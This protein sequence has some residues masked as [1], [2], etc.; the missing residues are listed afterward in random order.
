MPKKIKKTQDNEYIETGIDRLLKAVNEK[1]KIK[2]SEAALMF[3]VSEELIED[4]GN[5]LENHKMITMRYPIMGEPTL[6]VFVEK[7]PTKK[8]MHSKKE[9]KKK[10]KIKTNKKPKKIPKIPLKIIIPFVV[11]VVI[12]V[13]LYAL[14]VSQYSYIVQ[15]LYNAMG[16]FMLL[17]TGYGTSKIL[18]PIM[19]VVIAIVASV[20]TF[21]FLKKREKH[22]KTGGKKK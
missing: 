20:G 18:Y 1:K 17:I 3:N 13:V 15:Q 10:E 7:R 5:V 2:M 11:I 12:F 6:E 4:W 9:K 16:S 8:G 19:I 22:H 21:F 14:S